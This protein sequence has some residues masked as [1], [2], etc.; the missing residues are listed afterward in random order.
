[1]THHFD[2]HFEQVTYESKHYFKISRTKIKVRAGMYVSFF[3]MTTVNTQK[4]I[5][6][7]APFASLV[8][9]FY[10]VEWL[11]IYFTYP[12]QAKWQA[13]LFSHYLARQLRETK[14]GPFA[15]CHST[16]NTSEE[17]ILI[18]PSRIAV[19][20]CQ[21]N[22][23]ALLTV[24]ELFYRISIGRRDGPCHLRKNYGCYN[25]ARNQPRKCSQ[26]CSSSI[27]LCI[28]SGREF[29]EVRETRRQTY[30]YF[31]FFFQAMHLVRALKEFSL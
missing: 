20:S 6:L 9:D 28:D 31:F 2:I 25:Y 12:L 8:I 22:A 30:C 15:M 13:G 11:M 3:G 17:T 21:R 23:I 16:K 7:L 1:M 5:K 29:P 26:P 27:S 14:S 4:E 24:K 18:K 10:K 19:L